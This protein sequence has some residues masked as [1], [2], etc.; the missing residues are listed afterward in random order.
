MTDTDERTDHAAAIRE[1]AYEVHNW[2]PMDDEEYADI[3]FHADALAAERDALLAYAREMER[4]IRAG[5]F[6]S[7]MCGGPIN[8]DD[9]DGL[10]AEHG[11]A[12]L[13]ADREGAI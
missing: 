6:S 9:I 1:I 5:W 3:C 13:L 7:D 2:P 8:L 11:V 12:D 10:K 4:R